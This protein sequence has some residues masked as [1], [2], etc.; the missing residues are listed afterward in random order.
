ML[1]VLLSLWPIVGDLEHGNVNLFIL[2]V[3]VAGLY[4]FQRRTATSAAAC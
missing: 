1:V 2:F 4:L 3:V